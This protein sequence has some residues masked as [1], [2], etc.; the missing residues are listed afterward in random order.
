VELSPILSSW[1]IWVDAHR[2][3]L[4]RL[5]SILRQSLGVHLWPWRYPTPFLLAR[6][7][8]N[9]RGRIGYARRSKIYLRGVSI[10]LPHQPCE[11]QDCSICIESQTRIQDTRSLCKERPWLT[12]LDVEVFLSGWRAG[13]AF[14]AR[15]GKVQP[16]P[17]ALAFEDS[18]SNGQSSK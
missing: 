12:T 2:S 5:I 10:G 13:S 15:K 11:G 4:S 8:G 14:H 18:I 3:K 9:F 16:E 17:L 6:E 1:D 7:F